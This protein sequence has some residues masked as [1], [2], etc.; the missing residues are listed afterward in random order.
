VYCD[1]HSLDERLCDLGLCNSSGCFPSG[2]T[3]VSTV[4]FG[5]F[6]SSPPN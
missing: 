5:S 3:F 1:C 2:R 6:A 4:T